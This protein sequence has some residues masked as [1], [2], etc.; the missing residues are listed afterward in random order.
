MDSNADPNAHENPLAHLADPEPGPPPSADT[1]TD[2]VARYRHRR[3]RALGAALVVALLAGPAVGFAVGRAGH[4][5]SGQTVAT[6]AGGGTPI[7]RQDTANGQSFSASW[8]SGGMAWSGPGPG[9]PPRP[10]RLFLRDSADGIRVRAYLQDFPV[11]G[12]PG[13]PAGCVPKQFLDAQVSDDAM[14][15]NAQAPLFTTTPAPDPVTVLGTQAVGEMEGSPAA[16]ISIRTAA[17]VARVKA[18]FTG[19][20]VDE[21]A[22]VDGWA[23]LAGHR[24]PASQQQSPGTLTAFDAA[25]RVLATVDL[26]ADQQPK[27]PAA[28]SPMLPP[29]VSTDPAPPLPPS[30][31]P[32]TLANPSAAVATTV[33]APT[34]TRPPTTS[35]TP[36]THP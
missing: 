9:D 6:A 35:S 21:M 33:P 10:T 4:H 23:V 31:P 27:M 29:S 16:V 8:A 17:T 30:P 14:A 3:T 11:V 1:L 13:E 26:S 2:I 28:C 12:E 7:P 32:P 20:G 18:T 19:G 36:T 24:P 25:G 5:G 15:A 22:P 34:T